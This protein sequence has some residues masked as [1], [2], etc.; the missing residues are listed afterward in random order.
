M[1]R[2]QINTV[3]PDFHEE[4]ATSFKRQKNGQYRKLLTTCRRD[5]KTNVDKKL[6]I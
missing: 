4:I 1:A 5:W 3:G 2:N 6:H